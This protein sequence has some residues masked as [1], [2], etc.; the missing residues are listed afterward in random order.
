MGAPE[1]VKVTKRK[2]SRFVEAG[3]REQLVAGTDAGAP[4]FNLHS[5]LTKEIRNL[6]EAGLTPMEA[7]QAATLR[8]AQM[9]GA[10]AEL[11]TVSEGKLAD[12]IVVDGDPLQDLSLLQHAIVVVISDGRTYFPDHNFPRQ[13]PSN[14]R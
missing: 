9:Q 12:L 3:G 11:G 6:H 10:E 5:P 13:P 2:L 7:I 1:R 4:P 8:A 14:R